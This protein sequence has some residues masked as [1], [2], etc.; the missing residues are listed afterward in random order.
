MLRKYNMQIT[1]QLEYT[2]IKPI[3]KFEKSLQTKFTKFV[4]KRIKKRRI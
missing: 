2:S 4:L 1:F 3:V